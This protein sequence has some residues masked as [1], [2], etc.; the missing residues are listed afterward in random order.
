MP[1]VLLKIERKDQFHLITCL[2]AGQKVWLNSSLG[3]M[4]L[5]RPIQQQHHAS[6]WHTQK[7]VLCFL[8][9]SFAAYLSQLLRSSQSTEGELS[10][11]FQDLCTLSV[12]TGDREK[13]QVFSQN[14]LPRAGK[15][16]GQQKSFKKWAFMVIIFVV[17]CI[18]LINQKKI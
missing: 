14:R 2:L 16:R 5:T 13:A 7:N 8:L 12:C 18:P 1:S 11:C 9:L 6:C 15:Q 10:G 4:S 3:L 17:L